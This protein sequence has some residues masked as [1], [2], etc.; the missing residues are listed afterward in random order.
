MLTSFDDLTLEPDLWTR[1]LDVLKKLVKMFDKCGWSGEFN[2]QLVGHSC[3]DIDNGIGQIW[4]GRGIVQCDL[5]GLWC[6]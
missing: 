2:N 5:I 4:E 6:Q 3:I 1:Y